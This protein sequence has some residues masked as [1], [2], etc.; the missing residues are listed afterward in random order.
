MATKLTFKKVIGVIS[1]YLLIS[2]GTL[3]YVCE[4]EFFMI[5][6][7]IVA[8]GLT[9]ACTI[10]QFATNGLIPVAYSFAILNAFLLLMAFII[11]GKSFGLRTIY[12]IVFSTVMFKVL[13][14]FPD[15][16]AL[17]GNF[18]YVD[19]KILIPIIGGLLEAIG[20][21]IIFSRDAS[22]GGTDILALIFNKFWPVSP[23]KVYLY[24]DLFIVASIMFIPGRTFSDVIY[25]YLA[26][27]T[28]S[29]MVDFVLLG[30][31]ST[32]QVLVFSNKH[33][34]IAEYIMKTMNRGVTSL[35]ATGCYTKQKR[36][37]LLILVLKNQLHDLTKVIKNLDPNAFVSVSPASSVYGEGFEEIKVGIEKKNKN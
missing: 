24:L 6:N 12:C 21:G 10:L 26:M 27:I 36:Q 18:L 5:P 3:L 2:L 22:T 28:F 8:G 30:R 16:Q 17:P 7:N 29:T 13:P 33:E 32:V 14:L 34:E 20:I 15:F 9:G 31:K 37:V 23:G 4:W 19:N 11:L 25:G 35:N 1:D